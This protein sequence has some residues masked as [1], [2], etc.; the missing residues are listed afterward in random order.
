[1]KTLFDD[2]D[3]QVDGDCDPD[4]RLHRILGGAEE[5]LDAEMLLD[6]FEEELHPPSTLVERAN[7]C[8]RKLEVIRQEDQCLARFRIL[9]ANTTEMKRVAL[10]RKRSVECDRLI[11]DDAG[12]TLVGSRVDTACGGVCLRSG[13]EERARLIECKKPL[14]VEVGPVHYIEGAGLRDQQIEHLDVV[15][16]AI[17]DVD[18]ARNRT[19]QIEQSV[20][21][22]RRFGGAERR[23]WKYREAEIDRGCVQR[24]HRL[25]QL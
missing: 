10:L 7:G 6:P 18:E 24:V 23:P 5:R 9:E 1:M 16:F 21:L 25:G 22:D 12:T 17:G 2:G 3:Q 13:D 8:R 4:L 14:E 11:A 19:A 15:Q 20:Q